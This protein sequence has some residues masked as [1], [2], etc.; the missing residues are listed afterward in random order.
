MSILKHRT[1]RYSKVVSFGCSITYGDGLDDIRYHEFINSGL[2]GEH[3][4]KNYRLDNSF[5]G[6]LADFLNCSSENY[7]EK[8][9]NNDNIIRQAYEYCSKLSSEGSNTLIIVQTTFYSRKSLYDVNT[10]E[11]FL[12]NSHHDEI[13]NIPDYVTKHYQNYLVNFYDHAREFQHTNMM[14][15]LLKN[16]LAS[17][18]IDSIFLGYDSYSSLP[19]H[20]YSFP[21]TST[22]SLQEFANKYQLLIKDLPGIPFIDYHLTEEGHKAVAV[23]LKNY[24]EGKND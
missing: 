4:L 7:G 15:D 8:S 3:N 16:L 6:R 20:Y 18:G 11:E 1:K 24:L 22:G 10:E 9:N 13:S 23:M 14:V 2:S 17:K 5:T 19:Q 21:Y 12:L